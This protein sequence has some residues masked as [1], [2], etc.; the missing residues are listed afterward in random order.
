[1][2]E[3]LAR[4][5]SALAGRYDVERELGAGGMATVFLAR[6]L[7]HN[8]PVA[9]KVLSPTLVAGRTARR[10]LTEVHVTANLQHPNI[11]PLHDSG[12]ADGLVYYVMPYVEGERCGRRW[13]ATG[14]PLAEALALLEEV[15]DA[16]ACAHERGIVHRDIKPENIL[17]SR[18]HALVADF[19]IAK[20]TDVPEEISTVTGEGLAVGTPAYMAPEQA[21]GQSSIGP[22]ADSYALGLLAFEVITGHHPFRPHTPTGLIARASHDAGAAPEHAVRDCPPAL[23]ELVARL[24]AKRPEDRPAT[25]GRGLPGLRDLRTGTGRRASRQAHRDAGGAPPRGRGVHLVPRARGAAPAPSPCSGSAV[26][27]GAPAHPIGGDSTDDYFGDGIADELIST[28]GQA[29]P[30]SGSR[31][32]PP[33]SRSRVGAATYA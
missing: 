6:D 19:G 26:A 4:I 8:R 27:R 3:L 11:L 17:L 10:F 23:D 30:D 15:A 14:A 9:I 16:L 18:G 28:L 32:E 33:P 13:P 31:R 25:R 7:R 29:C 5:R 12:E 20:A 1:M 21:M 2:P 22:R 24:L